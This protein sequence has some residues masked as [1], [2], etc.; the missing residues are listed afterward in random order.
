ME[1]IQIG[2][3]LMVVG[4]VTVFL[5]LLILIYLSQSLIVLVNKFAPE[6]EVKSRPVTALALA[7]GTLPSGT[8]ATISAAVSVVTG[9]K[10]KVVKVEKK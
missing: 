9:G 10:G 2:L 1:N 5:I 3:L 8:L 7:G 4:I 6:E